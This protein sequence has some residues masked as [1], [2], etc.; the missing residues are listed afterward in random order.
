MCGRFALFAKAGEIKEQFSLGHE[1]TLPARYNIAPGERILAVD[2]HANH[3]FEADWF[4]WGLIPSW[5]KDE[6]IGY[7]MSNARAETITQKPT[8]KKAFKSR[9]C[10][11]VVNGF[12]EWHREGNIKQPYYFKRTDNQLFAIAAI[13]E[14]WRNPDDK[15]IK[16]CSMITT[17]ANSLMKPIHERMPAIINPDDYPTWLDTDDYDASQLKTLL[18]PDVSNAFELYP[19]STKVNNARYHEPDV[20]LPLSENGL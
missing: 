7:K 20:I 2:M 8:F 19:V 1:P 9:R 16:S 12:Y 11:V 4:K 5:A 10:L 13:W 17:P 14:Y 3:Q 6:K 18:L 15:I